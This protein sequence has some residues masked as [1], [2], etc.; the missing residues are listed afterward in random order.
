MSY[1]VL[2]HSFKWTIS[3]LLERADQYFIVSPLYA[4]V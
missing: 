3:E 2:K 1:A 4:V